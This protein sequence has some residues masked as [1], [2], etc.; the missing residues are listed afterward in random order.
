MTIDIGEGI[1]GHWKYDKASGALIP[2]DPELEKPKEVNAP[3]VITDDMRPTQ[4]QADGKYYTSKNKL[5]LAYKALGKEEVGNTSESAWR[6]IERRRAEELAAKNQADCIAD[7]ERAY[8]ML[9]N[10]DAP[11]TEEERKRCQE[12]DKILNRKP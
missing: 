12:Q 4:N 1:R 5:R 11:I 6:D 9:K 2:Y 8:H 7:T 10:G 3:Y